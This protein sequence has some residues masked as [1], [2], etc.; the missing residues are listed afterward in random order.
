MT[1]EL[2]LEPGTE[3]NGHPVIC[4][5]CQDTFALALI[6]SR[7]PFETWPAQLSCGSCGK[8]TDTA[9]TN[10]LVEAAHLASRSTFEFAVE[11]RELTL[12]GTRKPDLGE[13]VEEAAE[14]FAEE[15]KKEIK[16]RVRKAKRKLSPKLLRKKATR[17]LKST[18]KKGVR[19]AIKATRRR[20]RKALARP[21]AAA[22][23]AAW[24][25]RTGQD[26]DPDEPSVEPGAGEGEP[27][28][29]IPP[30]SAYFKALG[31]KR[32]RKSKCLVC[33]GGGKI[34]HP[35]LDINCPSC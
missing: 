11:W 14:Y 31:L 17:R 33:G 24:K 23:R 3:L 30:A 8:L 16:A 29:K 7:P 15:A 32:T 20:T 34:P 9:A 10:G 35:S 6:V 19:K 22:L 18:A 26:F 13:K 4:P 5:E 2:H 21:A 28:L 25:L 12:T 1:I 27:E